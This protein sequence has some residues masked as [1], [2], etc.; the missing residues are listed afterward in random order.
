[1]RGHVAVLC[2]HV[3]L[4]PENLTI[5]CETAVVRANVRE[6]MII[7]RGYVTMDAKLVTERPE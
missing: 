6:H 4:V 2:E 7:V 5:V 3:P 1:M